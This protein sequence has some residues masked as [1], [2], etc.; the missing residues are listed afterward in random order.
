M[1]LRRMIMKNTKTKLT[2]LALFVGLMAGANTAAYAADTTQSSMP[3]K[4]ADVKHMERGTAGDYRKGPFEELNLTAEQ[5]QKVKEIMEDHKVDR[6][7]VY[8]D[9]QKTKEDLNKLIVSDDF[10]EG[11]AKDII[12]DGSE[13]LT[14]VFVH[15]AT[16][17]HEVYKILTPE[18]KEKFVRM[19]DRTYPQMQDGHKMPRDWKDGKMPPKHPPMDDKMRTGDVPPPAPENK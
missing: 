6:K 8:K 11:K 1:T 14:D 12:E 19:L 13:K 15:K 10:S 17:D 18:Q 2:V 16:I 3:G 4:H 5:K 7:D 9:M